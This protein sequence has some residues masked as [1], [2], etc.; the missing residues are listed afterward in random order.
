MSPNPPSDQRRCAASPFPA[1]NGMHAAE[2]CRSC[3]SVSS[4]TESS[5]PNG[6]T[7]FD[8]EGMRGGYEAT[9]ACCVGEASCDVGRAVRS[10][11]D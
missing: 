8:V 6:L 2:G 5:A 11:D 1:T 3:R 4:S 9:P 7:A 10:T